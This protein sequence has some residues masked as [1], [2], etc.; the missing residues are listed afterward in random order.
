MLRLETLDVAFQKEQKEKI[1]TVK[2]YTFIKELFHCIFNLIPRNVLSLE[3]IL[4]LLKN[5]SLAI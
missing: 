5:I 2:N 1:W 3:A 4:L